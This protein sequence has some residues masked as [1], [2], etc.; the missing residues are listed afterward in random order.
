MGPEPKSCSTYQR[1]V[2]VGVGAFSNSRSA[3]NHSSLQS[4]EVCS[5][6]GWSVT[7]RQNLVWTLELKTEASSQDVKTCLQAETML[8]W[9]QVPYNKCCARFKIKLKCKILIL[10]VPDKR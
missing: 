10:Y 3:V 7:H 2:G 5:G 1:G 8:K 4:A 9:N 6:A